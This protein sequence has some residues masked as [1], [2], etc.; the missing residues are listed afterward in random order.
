MSIAA[1]CIFALREGWL[2][3][4]CFSRRRVVMYL[5]TTS[6]VK[7]AGTMKTLVVF[8]K[9]LKRRTSPILPGDSV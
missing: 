5:A 3:L 9:F 6:D 2:A 1:P 8:N 7:L 4:S